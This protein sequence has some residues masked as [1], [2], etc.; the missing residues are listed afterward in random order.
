MP[1]PSQLNI[2]TSS[3]TRLVKEEKSYHKELEQQQARI[4]KLEAGEGG[5]D[6]DGNG[7]FVLAQEVRA[8]VRRAQFFFLR[9]I[10]LTE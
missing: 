8:L 5:E 2:A 9:A 3:L 1:Q 6:E 10:R 7:E 4:A